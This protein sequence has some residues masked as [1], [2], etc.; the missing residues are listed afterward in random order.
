MQITLAGF[1]GLRIPRTLDVDALPRPE[2][3]TMCALV[4]A[5]CKAP[6][7]P[8]PR[9]PGAADLRTYR[10]EIDD[11]GRRNTLEVSD[12]INDERM[13]ALVQMVRAHLE[14]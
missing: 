12:P 13:S 7:V 6:H 14:R 10:L 5:L 3:D 9:A 4:D 1:P 8:P 11:S 2:R